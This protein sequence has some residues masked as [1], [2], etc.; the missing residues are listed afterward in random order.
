MPYHARAAAFALLLAAAPVALAAQ[1]AN[2][3]AEKSLSH[4]RLLSYGHTAVATSAGYLLLQQGAT[5]DFFAIPGFALFFYGTMGAPSYGSLYAGD[6]QRSNRGVQ[7]RLAGGTLLVTGIWRQI[8]SE[9]FLDEDW[10]LGWE[11]F[12]IT[13]AT[14]IAAGAA[15]NFATL[16]RSVRDHNAAAGERARVSVAPVLAPRGEGAGVRMEVRF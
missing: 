2:P 10:R 15:Y 6:L 9:D 5:S 4:A 1:G 11:A 3:A 16:P 12:T 13:G 14:V 8:L 7:I